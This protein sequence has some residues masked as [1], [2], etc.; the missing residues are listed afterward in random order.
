[1]DRKGRSK[2]EHSRLVERSIMP[3]NSGELT[4]MHKPNTHYR[5]WEWTAIFGVKEM[6]VSPHA[7]VF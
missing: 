3:L 7:F 6:P 2:I 4:K 5:L 1:M